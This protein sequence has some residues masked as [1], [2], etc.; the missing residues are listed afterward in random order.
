MYAK[1]LLLNNFGFKNTKLNGHHMMST[2]QR[3]LPAGAK[4]IA[5]R[6]IE[7]ETGYFLHLVDPRK[8]LISEHSFCSAY[9]VGESQGKVAAYGNY[10]VDS[11]NEYKHDDLALIGEA[12]TL[13]IPT[14]LDAVS[15]SLHKIE[16][17]LSSEFTF[18]LST[19]LHLDAS[20]LRAVLARPYIT[21]G[22]CVRLEDFLNELNVKH[23]VRRESRSVETFEIPTLINGFPE[24]SSK[25]MVHEY[26]IQLVSANREVCVRDAYDDDDQVTIRV[27]MRDNKFSVT[28]ALKQMEGERVY[29]FQF[30]VVSK[31]AT[32]TTYQLLR[33]ALNSLRVANCSLKLMRDGNDLNQ[34]TNFYII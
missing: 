2:L 13:A 4:T 22:E 5:P 25:N 12:D 10:L 32:L 33:T 6:T 24:C 29:Y 26:M 14:I 34:Y 23:V 8:L 15:C 18:L 16:E 27:D 7:L 21:F 20:L 30:V 17:L 31:D 3:I 11:I 28:N 19:V 9:I 1:L